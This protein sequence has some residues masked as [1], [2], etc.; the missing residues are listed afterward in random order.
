MLA[1]AVPAD[2]AERQCALEALCILDTPPE[3][4]FDRLVRLAAQIMDA[5]VAFLTLVDGPR[6]WAKARHG[7]PLVEIERATSFCGHTILEDR[8]LVVTDALLDPRFHDNPMVTGGLGIRFYAGWPVVVSGRRLGAL[9]VCDSHPR[10]PSAEQLAAL[11]D[12][13]AVAAEELNRMEAGFANA[14]LALLA[15]ELESVVRAAPFAVLT[16]D[17]RG[18][19]GL[20]N[21]EAEQLFGW[22]EG[23]GPGKTLNDCPLSA[24]DRTALRHALARLEKGAI[25]A[26]AL[27]TRVLRQDGQ[28][29]HRPTGHVACEWQVRTLRSAD[30]RPVH[31]ASFVREIPVAGDVLPPLAIG[32]TLDITRPS[33]ST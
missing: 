26:D 1:P 17:R 5:H 20:C 18:S 28:T 3:P 10:R 21:A 24:A 9:C 19:I 22:G 4:R 13:A 31:F 29:P 15:E 6:L 32:P 11:G 25:A 7:F 23:E 27:T 8:P 30:G 2:E 12:L 14:E 33:A 16:H